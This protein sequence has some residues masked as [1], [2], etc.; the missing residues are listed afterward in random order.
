MRSRSA[1]RGA[2]ALP[3]SPLSPANGFPGRTIYR[4]IMTI[5]RLFLQRRLLLLGGVVAL[6]TAHL[7][8]RCSAKPATLGHDPSD[9]TVRLSRRIHA[10]T[11]LL[12][13][14]QG[15]WKGFQDR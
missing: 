6:I 4:A 3:R 14:G 11:R 1:S 5:L 7:L 2:T 13:P 10:A 9:S 12:L 8:P 15:S